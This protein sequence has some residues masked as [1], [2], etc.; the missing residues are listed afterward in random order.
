MTKEPITD[1]LIR[2]EEKLDAHLFRTGTLEANDAA[3]DQ[4]IRLLERDVN[5]IYGMGTLVALVASTGLWQFL[6]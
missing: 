3:Q 5:R 1:R 4:N 6:K 2:M